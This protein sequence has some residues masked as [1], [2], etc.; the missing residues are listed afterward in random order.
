MGF[1][2]VQ[3][4]DEGNFHAHIGFSPGGS[5]GGEGHRYGGE[6]QEQHASIS[7]SSALGAGPAGLIS[8]AL[9]AK[10][11]LENRIGGSFQNERG[12]AALLPLAQ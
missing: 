5:A 8:V 12:F 2:I 10:S 9:L 3:V 7:R 1:L 6:R 11:W 4:L